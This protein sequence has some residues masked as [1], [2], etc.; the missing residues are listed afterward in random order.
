MIFAKLKALYKKFRSRAPS[1]IGSSR[2]ATW[3]E[4]AYQLA[5]VHVEREGSKLDAV[6]VTG[7]VSDVIGEEVVGAA[8]WLDGAVG[9]VG[10][11]AGA[12]GAGDA[13]TPETVVPDCEVATG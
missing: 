5:Q 4:G 1:A 10:A 8:G 9:E 7:W 2:Q 6:S 12:V 13:T 3:T 11:V